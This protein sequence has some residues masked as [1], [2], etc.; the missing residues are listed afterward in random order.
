M[1]LHG[2]IGKSKEILLKSAKVNKREIPDDI[3]HRL[4]VAASTW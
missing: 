4:T 1:L 2:R 3:D